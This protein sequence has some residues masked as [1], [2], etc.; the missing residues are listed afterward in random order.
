[1]DRDSEEGFCELIAY[2]LMERLDQPAQMD[3]IKNNL[4]TRG[5]FDLLLEADTTYGFYTVMQWVKCGTD[6][7]LREE[8]PDRIRKI[9]EKRLLKPRPETPAVPLVFAPTPV[10]DVLTLIGISGTGARRLALINDRAFGVSE[11]GKVRVGPTNVTV[12][13]LELRSNSVLIEV[14]G[15]TDKQELFLKSK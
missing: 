10:P 15:L 7:C 4:Y 13:C 1:M 3:L 8:E 2:K 14:D 5:Q 9:D 11:S 6:N 12:R